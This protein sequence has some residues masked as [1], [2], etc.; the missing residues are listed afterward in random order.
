MKRFLNE[1]PQTQFPQYA[2]KRHRNIKK[3]ITKRSREI[4]EILGFIPVINTN[5]PNRR[6]PPK[7]SEV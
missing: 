3:K 5:W 7:V 2:I 1:L 6:K 4:V